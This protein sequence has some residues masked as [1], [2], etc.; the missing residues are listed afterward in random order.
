MYTTQKHNNCDK[1]VFLSYNSERKNKFGT[2]VSE[3]DSCQV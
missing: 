1:Y 2:V 3:G